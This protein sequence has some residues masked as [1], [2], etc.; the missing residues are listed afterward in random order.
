MTKFCINC[1]KEISEGMSFC[2]ECGASTQEDK[3]Q[4][5]SKFQET[6]HQQTTQIVD[7][8]PSGKYG[9]VGTGYFF[10]M[11]FLYAIPGIGWLICLITVLVAKNE[12]KKHFAK[13]MLIWL[14][15]GLVLAI[16]GYFIFRWLGGMFIDY[17][18]TDLGGQYG[19]LN[20]LFEQIKNGSFNLPTK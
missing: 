2:T 20:E 1:G 7:A 15:I 16:V 19:D 10:V 4:K 13:A 18:N 6:V 5:N 3:L 14:I 9:V 17:I 12:N 11:M 8:P